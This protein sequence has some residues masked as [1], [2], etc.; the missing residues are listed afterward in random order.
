MWWSSQNWRNFFPV[1]CVPLSVMMELGIPKRW[2]M[3]V[4]NCTACSDLICA[5]GRASIHLEN[6]ST[7]TSRWVKPPG[8]FLKGPTR[9]SP[10]TAKGHVMG[11]VWSACAG[12]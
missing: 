12:R 3:S 9:S 2:M 1:N 4:K 5:T 11:I 6:L 10:Q 8:A 7:A